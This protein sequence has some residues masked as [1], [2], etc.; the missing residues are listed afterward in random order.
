MAP[1]DPP[2]WTRSATEWTNF[3][4]GGEAADYSGT[5]S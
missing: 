5:A 3:L 4:M 1:F 2:T